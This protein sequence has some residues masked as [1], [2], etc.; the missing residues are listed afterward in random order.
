[1]SFDRSAIQKLRRF[2]ADD[3]GFVPELLN[4]YLR[5]TSAAVAEFREAVQGGDLERV[6]QLA[7]KLRGSSANIGATGIANI[8]EEMERAIESDKGSG[9][10]RQMRALQQEFQRVSSHLAIEAQTRRKA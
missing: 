8:C 10:D 7:H 6:R 3:P 9:L 4:T 2:F 1:M 5:D